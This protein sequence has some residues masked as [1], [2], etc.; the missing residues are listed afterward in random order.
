MNNKNTKLKLKNITQLFL[1]I[2]PIFILIITFSCENDTGS[3]GEELLP[4]SDKIEY[5][6][7]TTLTFTGNVFESEPIYT[8]NLSYYSLG[9]INDDNFG[10]FKGEY[11]G[12]FL[13]TVFDDTIVYST[14][15]SAFL[16]IAIDSIYGDVLNN[17]SFNVYEL[18]SE[19]DDDLYMS[20]ANIDSYYSTLNIIGS[21][22]YSGD[23]LLKTPLN[24]YFISMLTSN[25]ADYTDEE[26][27]ISAFKGIAIIPE[28]SNPIGGAITANL[29]SLD[30]KIVLYYGDSL[31]FTYV[32]P[33]SEAVDNIAHGFAKY[34]YDYSSSVVNEYLTNDENIDDDMLFLQGING[35]STKITFSNIN[36][37]LQEDSSFSILHAEL[38]VPVFKDDNFELFYP[39]EMLYLEYEGTDSILYSLQ[40]YEGGLSDGSY[41]YENGY[42]RF[43]ISKYLTNIL[44]GN[45]EDLTLYLN[46]INKSFFP[47]RVI[48]KSS[49]N[50][51]LKVTYTKH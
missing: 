43:F 2:I 30:T 34:S 50:I 4:D 6:Y 45:I 35:V 49:E 18:L 1:G 24:D 26:T 38:Q 10:M 48:L 14:I 40:D 28:I 44:S 17:V 39:P 27:F 47:H 3:L 13:P 9:I 42:Y 15:D 33:T 46:I 41:D 8:S 5:E 21:S 22:T 37:W 29:T 12:Q 20:D 23:T 7:D 19:I 25:A 51:K 36:S 32:L 31:S 11:A 16:F